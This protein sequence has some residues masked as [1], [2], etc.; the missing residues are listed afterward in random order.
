MGGTETT[1]ILRNPNRCTVASSI[2]GHGKELRSDTNRLPVLIDAIC[3]KEFELFWSG[4]VT[5]R[6]HQDDVLPLVLL[7]ILKQQ[8]DRKG[9]KRNQ[10]DTKI[11]KDE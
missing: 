10:N 7:G 6:S 4:T 3:A 8:K 5:F 1:F 2:R 9:Y 11:Q